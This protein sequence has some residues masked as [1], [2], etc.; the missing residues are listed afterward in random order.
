MT[1][2]APRRR[3]VIA[4][5]SL[6]CAGVLFR[7]N[8][9]LALVSRGDTLLAGGDYN[10]AARLYARAL[11][12]DRGASVAADRLAFAYL[13]RRGPGDAARALAV[14]A[15]ALRATPH[16]ATLL[17]DRGFAAARLGR[18]RDAESAFA[19]AASSGNEPRYDHFAAHMAARA[20]DARAERAH[21][22]AALALDAGYAP[23]RALLARL[24]R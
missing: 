1:T 23:A 24:S 20:H 11:L 9:A 2:I 19:A 10:A 14:T 21:L 7:A 17:A 8:V 3:I 12:F 5:A 13:L 4:L 15:A 16:D 6:V 18:W 22:R